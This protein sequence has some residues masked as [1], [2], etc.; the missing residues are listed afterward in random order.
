MRTRLSRKDWLLLATLVPLFVVVLGAH[1]WESHRA[2]LAQLPVFAKWNPGDYPEVGGYRLETDSSGSGLEIGDRLIRLGD[3]DLRGQGYIGF[4]AI[5]LARTQPGNPAPLVF[6]RDGVRREITIESRPHPLPF[7]RVPLLLLMV[8][9]SVWLLIRAPGQPDV[10]L[11]CL[12]FMTYAIGQAHFYGGPEWQS[13]A[14][15]IVWTIF[16]VVALFLGP[17]W[18]RI[19]PSEVP[20]ERRVPKAVPWIY[21]GLYFL[22][23]RLNYLIAWPLPIHWVPRISFAAHGVGT[24]LAV[25]ILTWNYT[26]SGPVGRR[27]LRWILAG[28]ALGS[29]PVLMIGVAPVLAPDWGGFRIA[30][31]FGFVSSLLWVVG[32]ALA[33]MRD[34]A[35][36]VDRIIGVATA[37][38]LTTGAAVAGLVVV[39]PATSD[40]LADTWAIDP[41]VTRVVIAALVG[42]AVVVGTY[43]L[44]PYIE[45]LL[46]PEQLALEEAVAQIVDEILDYDARDAL[47]EHATRRTAEVFGSE[48]VAIYVGDEEGGGRRAAGGVHWPVGL[49]ALPDRA[50]RARTLRVPVEL[51]ERAVLALPIAAAGD[52]RGLLVLGPKRSGDIYTNR[53]VRVLAQITAGIERAWLRILKRAADLDSEAKTNLLA[54]ASHDLRQP[55]HAVSLLTDALRGRL[56]DPEIQNLVGRI[57][58]STHELD[59]MLSSL[60]D[61][62]K[63]D[64]GGI[65][66][67]LGDVAVAEV[68]H[69]VSRD[70]ELPAAEAG[71]RLVIEPTPLWVRSD[72]RL[73]N[74]IVR[75]L[76][77]NALRYAVGGTV[78]V[79]AK[80]IGSRVVIEVR[81]DGPGIASERQQEIF[82][83]FYQIDRS[84]GQG[85]GLGLSIVDR[86]SR[87]LG[88]DVSLES[89]PGEGATFGLVIDAVSEPA[90][91]SES[92]PESPQPT[93]VESSGRRI[94][95]IDDDTAVR[96]AT[97]LLL[98]GWGFS[99]DAAADR[100][101]ALAFAKANTS[102]AMVLSDHA[103]GHD[104]LGP[105]VV[106]E[107]RAVVD[108]ELP[109]AIVMAESG[110][111]Q[112]DLVRA[113][114][115]AVLRKPV[116]PAQLRSLLRSILGV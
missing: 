50:P 8:G 24:I 70:F 19:F 56:D 103:L 47:F 11:F 101:E 37:G 111:E 84:S 87:L 95:L 12:L 32:A 113:K 91:Q 3:R 82:E 21:A 22:L 61:L 35:F 57:G 109:A 4:Q 88:H 106:E 31:T 59:E 58:E 104:E 116:R 64:A 65:E 13:R 110:P 45:R 40:L 51:A 67:E 2:G 41:A 20:E 100:A 53:D 97:A 62:S 49:A 1:V 28:T 66:P 96:E 81:D 5:G 69:A 27:Q 30:F 94:L 29:L 14:A 78:E 7:S 79:S 43:R 6:E 86:L 89:A 44:R 74:R 16:S 80:A 83:S 72:R 34:N 105:E 99:V 98:E 77:S 9:M 54:E 107:I 112:L 55:L 25:G 73:L 17:A 85:L 48:G 18:A 15:Q 75:N 90:V 26:Q 76:V 23:I 33:V 38:T 63:L 42:G 108:P 68:F 39:I 71:T 93:N 36:D 102:Y 60:L 52:Q 92:P 114:G 46:L 10:Q 115:F